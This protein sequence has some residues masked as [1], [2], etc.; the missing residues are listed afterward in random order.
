MED[1]YKFNDCISYEKTQQ[2]IADNF[3]LRMYG[4]RNELI[5]Y[6]WNDFDGQYMQHKGIDCSIIDRNQQPPKSI[7]ISEKF[8]REDWG[9]MLI[10]IYSSYPK[11]H[12]WGITDH[13]VD[14]Y[15]YYIDPEFYRGH[16]DVRDVV[17]G[18]VYMVRA[19][20]VNKIAKWAMDIFEKADWKE[21][22]LNGKS[23]SKLVLAESNNIPNIKYIKSYLKDENG[24]F[25]IGVSVCISWSNIS[26]YF[27]E[28]KENITVDI[29]HL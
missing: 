17:Y 2:P 26:K 22:W 1:S 27:G 16:R 4:N 19:D 9:D 6:D 20:V 5:R 18:K 24:R 11:T 21:T 7:N 3:Y 15:A 13:D 14:Y 8:R 25:W 29:N 28:V 12:G 10:E 23:K